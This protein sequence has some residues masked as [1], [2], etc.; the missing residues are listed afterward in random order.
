[1][2]KAYPHFQAPKQ[3]MEGLS[4][5]RKGAHTTYNVN[6]H[7]VWIPKYRKSVLQGRNLK[8]VLEDV[9]RGQSEEYNWQVLAFEAQP[10]HIHLFLS[11]PPS[12]PVSKVANQLK[13]Y[14]SIVLRRAFPELKKKL[15]D[16]LWAEG[17]YVSTAGYISEDKVKRYIEE[18]QNQLRRQR[19]KEDI[20][21]NTQR[22][23]WQSRGVS[24]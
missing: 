15:G 3:L 1:M 13:G 2:K 14:S 18:Q 21:Q 10:D 19:I 22:T 8:S 23:L 7:I 16:S 9:I 24:D 17:Y 4:T 20:A 12:I 11:V 6:Y 5:I